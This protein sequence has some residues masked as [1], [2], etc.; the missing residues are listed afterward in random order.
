MTR[1]T[2]SVPAVITSADARKDLPSITARFRQEGIDADP[3]FYGS[4]RKP[5]AVLMSMQRYEALMSALEDRMLQNLIRERLTRPHRWLTE[6]ELMERL[7]ITAEDVA[8]SQAWI[9]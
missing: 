1:S 7:G 4:H 8:K 6:D 9:E 2:P 3:V 5:E